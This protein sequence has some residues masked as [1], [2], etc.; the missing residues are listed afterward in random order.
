MIKVCLHPNL[1]PYLRKWYLVICAFNLWQILYLYSCLPLNYVCAHLSSSCLGPVSYFVCVCFFFV[2][3][4]TFSLLL[5]LVDVWPDWRW[6]TFA[7]ASSIDCVSKLL[8]AVQLCHF[9][10][11]LSLELTKRLGRSRL[12][13]AKSEFFSSQHVLPFLV[14]SS[15]SHL[16]SISLEHKID[17]HHF[18]QLLL[19]RA[20]GCPDFSMKQLRVWN[21]TGSVVEPWN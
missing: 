18:C 14:S 11:R 15:Y 12:E 19:W 17:S 9:V 13:K 20:E 16:V 7:G 8:S 6:M 3:P 21:L 5:H 2:E 4:T 10:L 1:H